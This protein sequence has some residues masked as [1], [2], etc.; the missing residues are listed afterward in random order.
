[1]RNTYW[2]RDYY[3]IYEVNGE[4]YIKFWGYFYD[5]CDDEEKPYR[6][7]EFVGAEIPL[8]D[9]LEDRSVYDLIESEITQ[10]IGDMTEDEAIEA[11]NGYYNGNPPVP[12][13][14][15]D[16]TM[17]TPC[18]DY[19][20]AKE[21]NMLKELTN[22]KYFLYQLIDGGCGIVEGENESEA[23]AN[24]MDAYMGHDGSVYGAA[25]IE[26]K[27]IIDIGN[28]FFADKPKVIELGWSIE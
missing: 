21:V 11:M 4:K 10:Y 16:V 23:K 14:L 7:L 3:S 25:D 27:K 17:E 8:K 9:Y 26:C 22:G 24:V 15:E 2:D 18:G 1:M 5:G 20:D 12:Y 28:A 19:I 13:P 6:C